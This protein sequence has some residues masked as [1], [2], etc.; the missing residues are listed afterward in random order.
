MLLE[1]KKQRRQRK[2]KRRMKK[3]GIL[4]I[5]KMKTRV[6]INSLSKA[7]KGVVRPDIVAY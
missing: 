4:V 1:G 5:S 2:S 6:I 3:T 7:R